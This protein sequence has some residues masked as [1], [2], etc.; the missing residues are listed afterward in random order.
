M[1]KRIKILRENSIQG[2]QCSDER[3][4]LR[5]ELCRRGIKTL[6]DV[7]TEIK[8][9]VAYYMTFSSSMWIK[10]EWK[11]EF[12]LEGQSI[13]KGAEE[14]STKGNK[15]QCKIQRRWSMA[16]KSTIKRERKGIRKTLQRSKREVRK[17]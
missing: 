12:S 7:N 17:L 9:G 2:K 14:G 16:R 3:L 4:Y 8:V 6:K 5:R 1:I 11:R 10:E 13:K 15:S